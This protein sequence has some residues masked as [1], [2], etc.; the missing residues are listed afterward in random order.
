[1][2]SIL[3]YLK[4]LYINSKQKKILTNNCKKY[5]WVQNKEYINFGIIKWKLHIQF[6]SYDEVI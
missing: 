2:H 4:Q 3:E 1:M 5:E 6:A